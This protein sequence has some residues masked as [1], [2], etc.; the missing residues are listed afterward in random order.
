MAAGI[1]S[2]DRAY[3]DRL[4]YSIMLH[5]I[6]DEGQKYW[7]AEIPELPGCKSHGLTVEEAVSSVN[8]AKDDWISDSLAHREDV[9]EPADRSKYNGKVLVRMSRS[10]HRSLALLADSENLSTNQL[11]VTILAKEV[12]RLG[13]L[14]RVEK[15]LDK[16]LDSVQE[17][18]YSGVQQHW[19]YPGA[20]G[21]Y[22]DADTARGLTI[23][24]TPRTSDDMATICDCSFAD[25]NAL[26][27]VS[28]PEN[29]RSAQSPA[30]PSVPLHAEEE[31]AS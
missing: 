30:R 31:V 14:N 8:E 3:Y 17:R 13:V 11:I 18:G 9:P 28:C 27:R 7:I 21:W 29:R 12:G 4:P 15:K 23:P 10:L 16:V 22:W 1:G 19:T 24:L 20:V 2:K 6:E 5:Q 25:T 26:I